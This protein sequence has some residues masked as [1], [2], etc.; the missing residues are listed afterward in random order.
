MNNGTELHNKILQKGGGAVCSNKPKIITYPAE[1]LATRCTETSEPGDALML[2]EQALWDE[3]TGS[4]LGVGLAANQIGLTE[5]VA[6]VRLD[7]LKLDLVNPK[8]VKWSGERQGSTEQCLSL[9]GRE[10]TV[11][12]YCHIV[13]ETDNYD[14]PIIA[15]NFDVSRVLQHEID[16]LMGRTILDH[17][18]VG[19][20]E[21]CPCGSGLKYKK[22]C[23]A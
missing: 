19:R 21:P 8:I 15:H 10:H 16:H 7:D 17:L 6:I 5:S 22:C 9:P 20:N 3:Q 4:Y 12:R 18:K 13:V 1:V 2:L 11:M 14:K 23:G